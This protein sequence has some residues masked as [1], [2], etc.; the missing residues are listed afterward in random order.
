MSSTWNDSSFMVT[1]L[2][3]CS[4]NYLAHAKT[5]GESVREHNPDFHFVIGLV[6]W[7]PKDLEPG[8]LDKFEVIPVE[9][10]PFPEFAGML[11][12][13]NLVEL[14]TA[15][16]PFYMDYLYKRDPSVE[17]VIYLDPDTFIYGSLSAFVAKLRAN[18]MVITPHSC[19]YDNSKENLH[20]EK[21]M[22][23]A[24][25]TNLAIQ[26]TLRSAVTDAFLQWWKIR[27]EDHCY[28]RPG[29]AGSFFD[30]LWMELARLYFPRVYMETDPGYNFCYW[31]HFERRLSLRN[32]RYVVNNKHDLIMVHFSGFKPEKPDFVSS[33]ATEPIFTFKER[34]DLRSVYYDYSKRLM[35]NGYLRIKTLPWH[36]APP[37]ESHQKSRVKRLIKQSVMG[38]LHIIPNRV[39]KR[40]KRAAQFIVLN[41]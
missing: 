37:K 7:M 23:W 28:Y 32:G 36:F 14:N 31:N 25:V 29:V 8:Y 22:L 34:P 3:L 6:D 12:K 27:L 26:G 41:S 10:F 33:R 9:D 18:N 39:K 4:A 38:T 5:L 15:V 16:K 2:T 35:E 1:I 21:V 24:G 19:T 11:K 30:Q 40:I 17:A 13:Y 20:Y